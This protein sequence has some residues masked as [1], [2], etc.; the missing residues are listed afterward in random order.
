M[1][2]DAVKW[3][4][5]GYPAAPTITQQPAAQ[6]VCPGATATF[7]VAASGTGT[8][9]YQWQKN[10]ANMN[11]VGHYSGALTATLTVSNVDTGDAANYRCVVSN[12]GG[13]TNSSQAALTVKAATAITQ[14]PQSQAVNAGGTATFSVTATGDGTPAY[15]WSKDGQP[16]SDDGRIVG[17]ATATL[18]INSVVPEDAGSYSVEVTGGCGDVSSQSAT[19]T[20]NALPPPQVT[21]AVSQKTHGSAG[22][23]DIDILATNA[24]ECRKNGPTLVLITFDQDIQQ[25]SGTVNDVSLSSGTVSALAISGNQLTVTMSGAAD[26]ALLTVG[27]PGIRSASG[28]TA[29]GNVCFAVLSGDVT[30]DRKVNVFDLQ[31]A[32]NTVNQPVTA[33]NFRDDITADGG[34]NVF[35]MLAV[36]NNLNKTIAG[37]C[38]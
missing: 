18:T 25:I 16:L 11:D 5:R 30:G 34:I 8:L 33:L 7:T 22:D 2:A 32:K 13:S 35:D 14:Q 10:G 17:A 29:T 28:Q 6:T 26:I 1:Y 15:A 12:A 31:A 9:T 4:Y 3:E 20:V 23:F 24:V 19:L 38:P 37:S 21:A 36:K 27:F